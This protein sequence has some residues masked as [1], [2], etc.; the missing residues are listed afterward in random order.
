[1][2]VAE[3]TAAILRQLL[4]SLADHLAGHG[5]AGITVID[6]AGPRTLATSTGLA[7]RLDAMQYQAEQGPCLDAA[8]EGHVVRSDDL[9]RDVRWPQFGPAAADW[10]VS[11]VLSIHLPVAEGVVGALNVYA[12]NPHAFDV[13]SQQIMAPIA[14]SVAT[15]AAFAYRLAGLR[16]AV[17]SRDLIGQAK[18]ILMERHRLDADQ[19]FAVLRYLS[20]THNVKLRQVAEHLVSTGRLIGDATV[21]L[22]CL[23]SPRRARA[24]WT[25]RP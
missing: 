15:A 10:G 12:D 11:S 8:I 14:S 25:G 3:D 13:Q 21:H 16:A 19:A 24:T 5:A 1:M 4:S 20:Q 7:E 9:A 6:H 18:G 2:R 22:D 23:E 17:E